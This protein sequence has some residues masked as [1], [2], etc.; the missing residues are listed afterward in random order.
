MYLSSGVTHEQDEVYAITDTQG[1]YL[2]SAGSWVAMEITTILSP[3]HFY[4][5]LPLGNKSL[6]QSVSKS[7]QSEGTWIFLPSVVSTGQQT[8]FPIQNS[9]H[10]F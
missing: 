7:E 9:V 8:P 4:A 3:N 5:I 10:F 1:D 2:P 6:D